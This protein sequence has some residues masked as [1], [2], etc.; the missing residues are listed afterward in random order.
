MYW[1]PYRKGFNWIN[2]RQPNPPIGHVPQHQVPEPLPPIGHVPQHQVPSQPLP[3]IGHVPQHHLPKP[4][5]PI[6]HVPQHQ[7]LDSPIEAKYKELIKRGFVGTPASAEHT[8]TDGVGRTRAY[9]GSMGFWSIWWHPETGAHEVHGA[10]HDKWFDHHYH[11][12]GYPITDELTTP[13]G[14]GRYNHFRDVNSPDKP[15]KSIYWT[16]QTGPHA[17]QG[18]I[19]DKWAE[20]GWEKSP[21]GYPSGDEKDVPGPGGKFQKFENGEIWLGYYGAQVNVGP[22]ATGSVS[23]PSGPT[24]PP[25]PT[26]SYSRVRIYN[27]HTDRRSII[28]WVNDGSGLNQVATLNHQYNDYG[29][30]PEGEP[31]VLELKNGVWSHVVCVDVGAIGCGVND[32]TQGACRRYEFSLLG[33][34]NGPEFPTPVIVN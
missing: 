8:V 34:S 30:C 5:P 14:R 16:P 28:I 17:V 10:I 13:D 31:H 20:I 19:R 25:P 1:N 24:P 29:T 18:K 6:G 12:F 33:N 21:I 27:C 26:T 4:L 22:P 7:M 2:P 32:P 11:L 3:P 15:E 23:T 9:N